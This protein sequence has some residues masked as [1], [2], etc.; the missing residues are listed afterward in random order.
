MSRKNLEYINKQARLQTALNA[1]EKIGI[2]T[3]SHIKMVRS[4]ASS[5]SVYF[6]WCCIVLC[7]WFFRIGITFNVV[8]NQLESNDECLK[9]PRANQSSHHTY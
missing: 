4:A 8:F 5:P 2:S 1:R 9:L 6:C 3:L 7:C